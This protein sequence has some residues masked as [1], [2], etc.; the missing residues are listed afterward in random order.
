M[1][2]DDLG[3]SEEVAQFLLVITVEGEGVEGHVD[4][5]DELG[6]SEVAEGNDPR[7]HG[8]PGQDIKDAEID[9][10]EVDAGDQDVSAQRVDAQVDLVHVVSHQPPSDPEVG[11]V[12]V[13]SIRN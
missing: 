8:I 4:G 9:H 5:A 2:T 3:D 1:L 6:A 11:V 10:S 7:V 13:V 12:L